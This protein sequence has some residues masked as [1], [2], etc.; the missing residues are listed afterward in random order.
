LSGLQYGGQLPGERR[1]PLHHPQ[2]HGQIGRARADMPVGAGQFP[3]YFPIDEHGDG[4][5][6]RQLQ[7]PRGQLLGELLRFQ[8]EALALRHRAL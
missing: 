7:H 3:V 1:H 5:H 2:D 4:A 6:F 8:V